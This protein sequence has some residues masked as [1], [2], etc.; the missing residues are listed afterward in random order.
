MNSRKIVC[1]DTDST[2]MA[3]NWIQCDHCNEHSCSIKAENS[4][5]SRGPINCNDRHI[6]GLVWLREGASE[7]SSSSSLRVHDRPSPLGKSTFL[8]VGVTLI[9]SLIH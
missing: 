4:F 8:Q 5:T 6:S 3:H 9:D 7:D 2:S 1:T